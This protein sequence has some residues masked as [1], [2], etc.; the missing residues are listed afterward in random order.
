MNIKAA[1]KTYSVHFKDDLRFIKRLLKYENVFFVIDKNVW[2]LYQDSFDGIA[3]DSLYVLD[4][5]EENKVID[6]A[7]DICESMVKMNA[8]RNAHLVSIGGGITQDV[9]GFTANI[10]YRGIKWTFV[11]TTL[12]ASCDSC[13]G[14]K[15]SLNYKSYKNLLGTFFPPDEIFVCPKFFE[16]L[17]KNDLESGLGEVVKFNVMGGKETLDDIESSIS[18]LLRLDSP[19]VNRFVE[20][21]LQYKKTIIEEDE[22]DRGRRVLLNFAHTFGHAFEASSAYEIPHGSAVALG[23][24][25]ANA[26]SVSR[27]MLSKETDGRIRGLVARILPKYLPDMIDDGAVISAIRKDKKQVGEMITAVLLDDSQNLHVVH[28]VTEDEVVLACDAARYFL[29][30]LE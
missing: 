28:D 11:P 12:L 1:I 21:S 16:T 14:G 6:T 26:I 29:D 3:K 9:T 15:T 23:M 19:T 8:K 24:V 5:C 30:S 25:S 18:S 20:N 10:L 13:I 2:I 4:A 7:L 27:Q 17:K 22:F